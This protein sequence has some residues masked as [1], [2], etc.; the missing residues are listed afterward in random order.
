MIFNPDNLILTETQSVGVP[1][2]LIF[3]KDAAIAKAAFAGANWAARY[4][5][6]ADIAKWE[7]L[8]GNADVFIVDA[9][10]GGF[11]G[12]SANEYTTDAGDVQT[13]GFNPA[14]LEIS[15]SNN[16]NE[17][18]VKLNKFVGNNIAIYCWIIDSNGKPWAFQ[19]ADEN[20]DQHTYMIFT[21]VHTEQGTRSNNIAEPLVQ[22]IKFY[23]HTAQQNIMWQT[24][25]LPYS[26]RLAFAMLS[27]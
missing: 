26:K 20:P 25:N 19:Y 17:I 6:M 22:K 10:G 4:A 12:G 27:K 24:V 21:N 5:D 23:G 15:F 8:I 7:A 2:K 9:Q 18:G 3:T 14:M 11:T 16:A 13:N 1:R